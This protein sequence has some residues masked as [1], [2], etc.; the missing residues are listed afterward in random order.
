MEAQLTRSRIFLLS[1]IRVALIL[2]FSLWIMEPL[3][4]QDR[5]ADARGR[6]V[7]QQLS[8]RGIK[9]KATLA[10]MKKVKRHLFVPAE[11]MNRE[12]DMKVGM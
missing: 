12:Q 6:M 4:G 2:V 3:S 1:R 8:D 9:D 10:A 11:Q 7:K 5:Y